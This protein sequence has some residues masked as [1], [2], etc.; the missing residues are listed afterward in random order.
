MHFKIF[1]PICNWAFNEP[2]ICIWMIRMAHWRLPIKEEIVGD[3]K[4]TI[5]NFSLVWV[6]TNLYQE[7]RK[8]MPS[9]VAKMLIEIDFSFNDRSPLPLS[10]IFFSCNIQYTLPFNKSTFSTTFSFSLSESTLF[11]ESKALK[12]M[13][14]TKD[15]RQTN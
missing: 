7:T 13:K 12:L 15:S 2:F 1:S 10:T 4:K 3:S 11:F 9:V 6:C 14:T 8:H 5:A